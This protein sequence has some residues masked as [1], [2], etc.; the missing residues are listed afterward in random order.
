M[1][2]FPNWRTDHS[3]IFAPSLHYPLEWRFQKVSNPCPWK[4]YSMHLG[5]LHDT[6]SNGLSIKRSFIGSNI[7]FYQVLNWSSL[8]PIWSNMYNNVH[9]YIYIHYM[10]WGYISIYYIYIFSYRDH[11]SEWLEDG[12]DGPTLRMT[13]FGSHAQS[14]SGERLEC[15]LLMRHRC[16]WSVL[17]VSALRHGETS[18]EWLEWLG[19]RTVPSGEQTWRK[20]TSYRWFPKHCG[21]E[22]PAMFTRMRMGKPW[23]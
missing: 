1:N 3:Q 20:S 11:L 17:A 5:M 16:R 8:C 19:T 6:S 7:A 22:F 21:E 23:W 4:L 13:S 14:A 12:Q 9:I 10:H 2:Q 15:F 18:V